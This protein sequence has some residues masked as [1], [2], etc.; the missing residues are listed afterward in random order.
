MFFLFTYFSYQVVNKCLNNFFFLNLVSKKAYKSSPHAQNEATTDFTRHDMTRQHAMGSDLTTKRGSLQLWQFLLKLLQ[1]SNNEHIIEWTRKS[2]AEFKLLDPEE[3]ARLWGISK[4]R[5]TMNYDKLSRS[6]R[7]YY[8]KGIM[9]KVSGERYVYRFINHTELYELIPELA[10][11]KKHQHQP[12]FMCSAGRE[13]NAP[14][15]LPMKSI[16]TECVRLKSSIKSSSNVTPRIKSIAHR[17]TPYGGVH[18]K[19]EPTKVASVLPHSSITIN[20]LN[21]EINNCSN[22]ILNATANTAA[23]P[24]DHHG[25]QSSYY[26]P[27]Y[28]SSTNK[29]SIES[30]YS[31]INTSGSLAESPKL[32]LSQTTASTV[33]KTSTPNAYST[34]NYYNYYADYYGNNQDNQQQCGLTNNMSYPSGQYMYDGHT[35]TS[36]SRAS[37][38]YPFHKAASLNAYYSQ[39]SGGYDSSSVQNECD[40]SYNGYH[41]DWNGAAN[42]SYCYNN[43][44]YN[45]HNHHHHQVNGGMVKLATSSPL[46]ISPSS[47][48][49]S[50]FS[51]SSSSASSAASSASLSFIN[52]QNSHKQSI[53][54]YY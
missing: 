16:K 3:V 47:T 11:L 51:N 12:Q 4:N 22:Y 20:N 46:S 8:E 54:N 53:G 15:I 6:L 9:Q 30:T 27:Q 32:A 14:K 33:S 19:S 24:Y 44:A 50:S 42:D 45:L 29:S 48:N 41:L 28:P 52:G 13:E 21:Y 23:T 1:M 43:N 39:Y 26:S 2:C 36:Q 49:S 5:P 17:Y 18:V 40:A 10:E 37:E 35:E 31:S 7:Y 25:Y 34:S 38:F